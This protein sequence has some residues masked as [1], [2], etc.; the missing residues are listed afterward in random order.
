LQSL[1]LQLRVWRLP[2]TF[3]RIFHG[4]RTRREYNRFVL[5][6]NGPSS[7]DHNSISLIAPVV[8]AWPPS[9]EEWSEAKGCHGR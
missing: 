1:L 7:L 8:A 3:G 5:G 6:F 2:A 4:L 9:A